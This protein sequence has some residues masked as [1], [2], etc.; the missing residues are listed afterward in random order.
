MGSALLDGARVRR[1][2]DRL[3]AG[4][5][6]SGNEPPDLWRRCKQLKR[7]GQP[8]HLDEQRRR[9]RAQERGRSQSFIMIIIDSN[10]NFNLDFDFIFNFHL[11]T[12]SDGRNR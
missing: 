10:F 3:P 7:F 11:G 8:A 5:A 6:H 1:R 2:A 9:D 4:L 12:Q